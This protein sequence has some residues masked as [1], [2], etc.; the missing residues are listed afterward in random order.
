MYTWQCGADVGNGQGV[1]VDIVWASR[2]PGQTWGQET[3]PG[4]FV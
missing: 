2:A 1:I 3:V 4:Q